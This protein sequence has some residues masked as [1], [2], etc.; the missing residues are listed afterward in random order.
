MA[1]STDGT[2]SC[3]GSAPFMVT[4]HQT[5]PVTVPVRCHEGAKTGSVL[6]TGAIN[7]CPQIDGVTAT[8][9]EVS[10]G[11]SI[12]LVATAHDTDA[13]PTALSY[14]WTASSGAFTDAT[15]PAT[16]FTCTV[17]GTATITLAASD[18]DAPCNDTAQVT[19][20]CTA[21][22]A[23]TSC[24]LGNGAGSIQHVVYLQFDNTHLQRD[25]MNVPSDLRADAA[26]AELHPRQ[27]GTMMAKA[28]SLR[29]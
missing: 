22:T 19:M 15:T 13:A 12:A 11:S 28:R 25:R 17:P 14:A 6:A 4:A 2:E 16:R 18:G 23:Q 5:T 8:P 9:T 1:T 7:V 29:S 20:T 3:S 10:V 24:R 21:L 26:R 27:R